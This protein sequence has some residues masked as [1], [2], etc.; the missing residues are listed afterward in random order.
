[1]HHGALS[2]HHFKVIILFKLYFFWRL[3]EYST[4][5]LTLTSSS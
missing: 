3:A 2:F 5:K 4:V 1:M